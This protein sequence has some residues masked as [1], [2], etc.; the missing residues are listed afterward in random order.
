MHACV[1]VCV[2]RADSG[3]NWQP[4]CR[5]DHS[6]FKFR[7]AIPY[8]FRYSKNHQSEPLSGS[9]LGYIMIPKWNPLLICRCLVSTSVIPAQSYDDTDIFVIRHWRVSSFSNQKS[10][11]IMDTMLDVLA[12]F[13]LKLF[14]DPLLVE[15]LSSFTLN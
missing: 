12:I 4:F 9:T 14:L 2:R 1:C 15:M 6:S 3:L 11:M 13:I 7:S 10:L 5:M 8:F